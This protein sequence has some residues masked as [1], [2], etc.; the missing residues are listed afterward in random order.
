MGD[1]ISQIATN[2]K[3]DFLST[4]QGSDWHSGTV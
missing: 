1:I 4:F 3:V 2:E